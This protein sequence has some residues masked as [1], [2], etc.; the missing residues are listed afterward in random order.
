VTYTLSPSHLSSNVFLAFPRVQLV[1]AVSLPLA[2]FDLP[3][4]PEHA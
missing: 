1:R 2:D 4:S 3:A